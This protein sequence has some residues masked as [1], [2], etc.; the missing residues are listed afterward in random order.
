VPRCD[1]ASRLH[2]SDS[3]S[4]Q[5]KQ[6]DCSYPCNGV[7]IGKLLGLRVGRQFGSCQRE[8]LPLGCFIEFECGGLK[9]A[10]FS[11]CRACSTAG[12]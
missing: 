3:E 12:R 4:S 5:Y 2:T 10:A 6:A 1:C 7:V 9:P 8:E 11:V